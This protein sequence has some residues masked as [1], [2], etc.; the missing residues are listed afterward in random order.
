MS[1]SSTLSIVAV[2]IAVGGVAYL[3]ARR[4]PDMRVVNHIRRELEIE[5]NDLLDEFVPEPV[6]TP[7]DTVG[8]RLT[9][10][11]SV[12]RRLQI[13]YAAAAKIEFGTP[14]RSKSN[15]LAVRDYIVR[16]MRN[17]HVRNCDIYSV[18]DETTAMVFVPTDDEIRWR[19]FIYSEAV[20]VCHAELDKKS[21]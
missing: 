21:C 9:K 20:D 12:R 13:R 4:A 15:L 14:E 19:Q 6:I 8:E 16:I 11:K 1:L 3:F 17:D 10:R 2:T 5:S 18:I 7:E